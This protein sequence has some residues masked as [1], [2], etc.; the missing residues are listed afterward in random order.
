MD[1]LRLSGLSI[2]SLTTTIL[3]ALIVLY[4]LSLKQKERD[5]W[6]L[7]GYMG[8]LFVLIAAY[9]LRYSIYHPADVWFAQIANLVVFGGV[10][11]VQFA[12]YYQRRLGRREPGIAL[13]VSLVIAVVAWSVDF[14]S[15]GLP[16]VPTVGFLRR[17]P[18]YGMGV[19]LAALIAHFVE[20]DFF[21]RRQHLVRKRRHGF[22]FD[23]RDGATACGDPLRSL[24]LP[25]P[26]DPSWWFQLSAAHIAH[27]HTGGR[28]AESA[29]AV[30]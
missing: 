18:L 28:L 11:L 20:A 4:L 22:Q 19:S 3:L 30:K 15:A 9:T 7:I 29:V 27:A 17:L 25:F 24:L 14:L 23:H 5:T 13:V 16:G 8:S 2:G 21:F 26:R 12:Y 6:H 10:C 1:W